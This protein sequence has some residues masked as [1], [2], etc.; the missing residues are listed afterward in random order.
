MKEINPPR[1]AT[2]FLHWFCPPELIEGIE[3][4]LLEQFELDS[5]EYSE[6]KAGRRFFLN[7]LKFFRPS[8]ILR[9]RFRLQRIENI[10]I[11]NYFKVAVRSIAKRKLY[12]FINA[13]GLSI[14]IAFC[15]LIYLFIQDERS[16]D[17]FHKNKKLIYR[18][19]EK[20]WGYWRPMLSNEPYARAPQLPVPLRDAVKDELPE[21]A[22]ATRIKTGAYCIVKQSDK[23]FSEHVTYVDADFF[24]MFSFPLLAGNR[25][26]LFSSKLEVVITPAIVK[27]YFDDQDPLGKTLEIDMEGKKEFVVTGVIEAPPANSSLGYSILLPLESFFL[28]EKNKNSWG[29][30]DTPC[31]VQ[32]IPNTDL[33]KFRVNL[34]SI[35][36]K[37][38]GD[39]IEKKRKESV[40]PIPA[41]KKMMEIDFTQLPDWHLNK[42]IGWYR[43]SD[44]Q[45]SYI[46]AGIAILI[47]AIASINYVS[48]VL[49]TSAS[50]RIEVGIRKVVG[51]QRK[52]LIWQFSIESIV[53]SVLS[54]VVAVGL[55]FL[56][57]PSF[58]NFTEKAIKISLQNISP[59]LSA[60]LVITL[61]IGFVAGCYPSFFLSGFR[62]AVVLKG[63]FTSK[64]KSDFTRPLVVLQFALSAFLITSSLI[65]YQQMKFITTKDLGY[66]KEQIL[67]MGTQ[68]GFNK[69]ANKMV[70]RMRA[71]L[72]R[73][74]NIESVAGTG[75]SFAQGWSQYGY[76]IKGEH[77]AAYVYGVDPDY[78]PTMGMKVILGRNFDPNTVSDSTAVVVNEALVRDLGWTDPLNEHLNFTEDSTSLGAKVIGV[79]KDY[80]FLSLEKN[81]EPMLLSM[82][83]Q[84]VGYLHMMHIKLSPGNIPEKI[85]TVR[86]AWKELA[87]GKPFE[88]SF[89]DENVSKQYESYERWMSIMRLSTVFAIMISCLGLFGLAGINAVNRTK[90]IGIRKVMGADLKN[91]FVL[92]N[93][94]FVWLA[95][96][97]F[98]LAAPLSWLVMKQWLK[99]FQYK[100]TVGWELFA[101]SMM[102]GLTV[103]L[104]TVSYHAIKTAMV[105]PADTLKYE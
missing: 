36:Q 61:L 41:D 89:L 100:I 7:A 29:S 71:R 105:N 18:L 21:V 57:L 79:V 76:K 47:L 82:T 55:V 31:I 33:G 40:E 80:H 48:L 14:G 72:K 16:F 87:P 75:I 62:P 23:V 97:A 1:L 77:K 2:R 32:L 12:S 52:Q 25:E 42:E 45:F 6:Q 60:S 84:K 22:Y 67:V 49:T 70:E 5:K 96:V 10:M 28:Y 27:K 88:Y 43:V 81:I 69:D 9:N 37:Y 13:I 39:R 103:A 99:D 78:I 83:N 68:T 64:M 86:K 26:K 4:D 19:E 85:E 104:L 53:L 65:M 90:E 3:G 56:F 17:Q 50:R 11:K 74:P 63:T 91:I 46:L 101:V 34:A 35:V 54:M 59:V 24:K 30:F 73:E 93:R 102:V 44:P 38:L 66:N 94:E 98:A 15:V 58:N 8:I 51:A 95:V 20:S 92:L